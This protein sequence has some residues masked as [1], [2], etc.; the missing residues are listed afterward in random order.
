[1][2]E[3]L[4][5]DHPGEA[6]ALVE[7]N[8]SITYGELRESVAR[9]AAGLVEAG[10]E[11]GDRVAVLGEIDAAVVTGLLSVFATGAAACLINALSPGEVVTGQLSSLGVSALLASPAAAELAAVGRESE[12][13]DASTVGTPAGF[14]CADLPAIDSPNAV[15]I[16][17][18]A[19]AAA[20]SVRHSRGASSVSTT[21]APNGDGESGIARLKLCVCA[22]VPKWTT[23][24]AVR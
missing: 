1:M 6:I 22:I 14:S 10:V 3:D 17:V 23:T 19:S 4:I 24:S 15:D 16:D 20:I 18:D 12:F 21:S 2:R 7:G 13:V 11:P 8:R 5:A 9:T